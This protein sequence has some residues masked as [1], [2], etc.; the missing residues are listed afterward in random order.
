MAT[1]SYRQ[2]DDCGDFN[3]DDDI[4]VDDDGD[5]DAW[6]EDEQEEIP[7]V[8]LFCRSTFMN[9]DEVFIHCSKEHNFNIKYVCTMWKLD[10]FGY[11]KMINYI[12][13]H[14]PSTDVFKDEDN[15]SNPPW[16]SDDYMYPIVPEDPMLQFDID[17][18]ESLKL[19]DIT[20]CSTDST[21]NHS[22]VEDK[23]NQSVTMTTKQYESLLNKLKES[24]ERSKQLE[25]NLQR[26]LEDMENMK[27]VTRNVMLSQASSNVTSNDDNNIIHTD[28]TCI[29]D[30]DDP[31]FSSYGHF[32]IHEEML[33]DKVR[34]ESYQD[35]MYK[36]TEVFK[37]KI[38]LDVGC[39]TGILSMF[40]VKSGAKHVYAVDMADIIYQA[41]DIARENN[42]SDNIT[43]I[44]G[45]L[46]DIKLPVDKVDIIISEW[47]GYFLLFES[48]LDSVLYARAKFLKPDGVVYPDRCN[49]S[50]CAI[51]DLTL[52][53]KHV[54]YWENVYGFKMNCMKTCVVREA[55]VEVIDKNVVASSVSVIKEIDVCECHIDDLQFTSDFTLTTT[56]TGPITALVGY[57]D[58]FFDKYS[59][60]KV[61]FSTG[62]DSIPTHWKQTVFLLDKPIDCQEGTV[63]KGK[64]SCRKNRKDTRSL[65]IK[66]T[67]DNQSYTYHME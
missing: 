65:I 9:T 62:P 61:S 64:L 38:V 67:L 5:D 48:M 25:E 51:N 60:Q 46:E 7:S 24:D 1:E 45:R 63:L 50:I 31:Y 30:S 21:V 16:N 10:C 33:K 54:K 52:Y 58:I 27:S 23:L 57:F 40:A 8:C 47:M 26:V 37:D 44:K 11:I 13:K 55:S 20:D 59:T 56:T 15:I 36:N 22:I 28:N 12:R 29:D 35:F 41:I 53:N 49:I 66:I 32:G 3:D 42:L 18:I 39:G 34:T 43:F 6:I 14:N 2:E 19:A 4:D 17:D